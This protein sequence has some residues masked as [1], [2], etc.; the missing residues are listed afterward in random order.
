MKTNPTMKRINI[1]KAAVIALASA[2]MFAGCVQEAFE[3]I[4]EINLTRCLEPQNLSVK[5][6][7]ATGDNVTFGWDVNK[8]ADSYNLVVYSDEAMTAKAL[9]VKILPTEVPYTVR[10]TADEKYYF[11]VQALS[12]SKQASNWAVYDGHASTYAVKDNLFLEVTSRTAEAIALKWSTEVSDFKEVTHIEAS[13]VK[14]GSKVKYELVDADKNSGT[15]TV[16]GLAAATEYQ[17]V[18]YYL[19]ASRG[20]VDAWTAAAPGTLTEVSTS[21]A[22][23]ANVTSGGE[24]Y[25]KLSGSP[26]TLGGSKPTASVHI[27]GELGD[28]GSRPVVTGNFD[29]S[30]ICASGMD[31]ICENV[32]FDDQET[33]NHVVNYSGGA[34]TIGTVKFV[35]CGFTHYKAGLFYNNKTGEGDILTVGD[36][37]FDTCDMYEMATA[38]GGDCI[39]FRK[40]TH[41]TVKSIQIVNCTIWD[42][43]RTLFRLGDQAGDVTVTDAVTFENNTVKNIVYVDNT[44]N[45]GVFAIRVPVTMTLKKNL[46]LY[47]DGGK[48]DEAVEDYAQLFQ[49]KGETVVPTLTAE[50]NYA[51]ACGK[52]FFKKVDASTAGFTVLSADPCYNSKG[53]FFQLSN[54]DLISKKVGAS[55]WW[56][57]YVEK[58][59]DLT[60]NVLAG[61]HPWNLQDAT[62]F[63][64]E[65]KNSRVRDELMMVGTEAT[66]LNGNNGINFL[67]ASVLSKKGV[68]TEGY[69]SFKVN[70]PGSVDLLVANGGA[71]S[72]VVALYDDNGYA[73]QGGVMTPSKGDV[74]KVIIPKVTGEGTVYLY[75]TGA[76]S[77]TKLAWSL[78]TAGGNR[79]LATPKVAVDPVTL[80]EGD[81]T[82]ITVTWDAV[83]HAAT[84]QV[85]FKNLQS[86]QTE[87]TFTIPA[88]T[89]A[90]LQAGLYTV[91]VQALPEDGDIYYLNSETGKAALAVQP[92][93]GDAPVEVTLT[94][95]FS[96][97]DWQTALLEQASAACAETNGGSNVADWAVSCNGLTYTS[98]TKN[99]RWSKA[100]WIQTNGAGDLTGRV[101]TFTAP[102]AGKLTII[103]SNTGNDPATDGR[104]VGVT[105]ATGALTPIVCPNGAATDPKTP[106]E[107]DVAAGTVAVYST[108]KG[109]RFYKIEF[110][111]TEA[112]APAKET[113]S[114]D[115]SDSEWQ[116]ALSEQAS[117]ACAETNGGSNVADW[118]V[119]CNG[120]TYTSGTKNG[121][122][123]QAGWIQTNGAGDLTGRVFTFTVSKA[124]KVS[125][126][127]SNTGNDPA[128][129]GR[130][131]GVTDATGALTPVVC[132]NGA[133]TDPKTPIEFDVEP[134]TVSIYSTVKGIR[135]YK[136]E[137]ESK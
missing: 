111:Y 77:L 4:T 123:S 25:L 134:G 110:V 88:E 2:T 47:V 122:W 109:I 113:H 89:I 104:G 38:P 82:D 55:K 75:A 132:P 12:E 52:D 54:P 53:N 119:S 3:E 64:G 96:D 102:A 20:A 127:C 23:V 124:G 42:G 40:N 85:M 32:I 34:T 126:I 28:D 117:A 79:L 69:L 131:V 67:G 60:Q 130:G 66:P 35:N 115:F 120:L 5:V 81:A 98:G 10:L 86:V 105:D 129:D 121:R 31:I 1:L 13:P 17:V 49:N 128:T 36:I 44:N 92:K 22:L 41:S 27:V 116:T 14:G 21:E 62:L 91:S 97:S 56:I 16:S 61:A 137:F 65:I 70:T 71:S 87:R 107:F 118:A 51:F 15:A 114:W 59:E 76:I 95:D 8:D 37:I 26:Y 45:R 100:G 57:S 94:W 48:T 33:H 6:D 125:I 103:G 18:L 68:P 39:D 83:P 93:G 80:T 11:K 74:Q 9:D 63:S 46:F 78:D 24:I 133:A 7:V 112:P 72:V 99:G 50:D 43:I 58:D 90:A 108:V 30:S 136:I 101:F 29:I 106:A 73:V 135:F 19:S 84:Y